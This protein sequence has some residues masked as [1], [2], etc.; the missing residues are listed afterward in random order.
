MHWAD[1][2]P[3]N[4][5]DGIIFQWARN[6]GYTIL[7]LDVDFGTLLAHSHSKY[8][9]I[10]QIRRENVDPSHLQMPLLEVLSTYSASIEEGVLIVLGERKVRVRML[11]L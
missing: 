4:A 7:T 1:V 8:P 3:K 2:G 11:P 10:I 9:G 5:D 6:N